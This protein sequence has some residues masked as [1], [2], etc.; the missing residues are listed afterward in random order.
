MRTMVL[1]AALAMGACRA[2]P[3][4]GQ[5]NE[6]VSNASRPVP[7]QLPTLPPVEIPVRSSEFT[8]LDPATCRIIEDNRDE[9]PYWRRRCRGGRG[10]SV[11]WTES[12]LRQGLE[13]ISDGGE[14]TNLR[15]SEL[16][17]DGA[18]NRLGPRIEWRGVIASKPDM[19]VVRLFVADGAEPAKPDRSLLA[20]ARLQP[21]PC[22]VAIVQP[23]RQQSDQ[24][25]RIADSAPGPCLS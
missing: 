15:L 6:V 19:L 4:D 2:D 23:G 18:F 24:A 22:V 5:A 14:R 7:D 9:G 21:R 16:V 25:R 3:G 13:L 20:V 12:D 11:E 10:Y 8:T 17:A 1:M